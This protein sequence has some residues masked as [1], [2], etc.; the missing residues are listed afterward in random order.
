MLLSE[1]QRA[2]LLGVARQSIEHGLKQRRPLPVV[3]AEHPPFDLP[4]ASFVTLHRQ[5]ALRGCIGSLEAHRPLLLDVAQNAYAAAFRDPRFEPLQ[6]Q[7]LEDLDIDIS[8][9][10][11]PEA[12][13]FDNQQALLDQIRPGV[14]GLILEDGARRGTFLPSVWSSLP[15]K[16]DFLAQLKL[17]A[18]LPVDYWSDK[19]KVWRYTTECFGEQDARPRPSPDPLTGTD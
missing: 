14:D 4:G 2:L 8:I 13:S 7:E 3:P 16:A 10:S 17:K 18:G 19:L 1:S 11:S 9:L 6:P 15:D 12:L 5:G